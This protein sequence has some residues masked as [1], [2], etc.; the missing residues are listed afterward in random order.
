MKNAMQETV[1]YYTPSPDGMP[2]AM[3]LVLAQLGI[4]FH[5]IA[6]HQTDETIGYLASIDGFAA[7]P[8]GQDAPVVTEQVL[9]LHNFSSQRLDAL[10]RGLRR[11]GVPPI[12]LKAVVTEHNVSWRFASLAQELRREHEAI[13]QQRADS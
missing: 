3:K 8:A 12:P 1:Y 10:L 6:P 4:R 2:T 7:Q 9:I 11:A 5:T 13:R